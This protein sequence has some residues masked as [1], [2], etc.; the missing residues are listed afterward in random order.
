VKPPIDPALA[1]RIELATPF[2][3]Q[4][5]PAPPVQE[6]WF[7]RVLDAI[8]AF[9]TRMFAHAH[10]GHG[11]AALALTVLAA[12]LALCVWAAVR[13]GITRRRRAPGPDA[14]T[15]ALAR[16]DA[17]LA[18]AAFEAADRG[19]MTTAV[20]LLLRAAVTLLDV[21]GAIDD[22]ASATIGQLR[23]EV[24]R[25]GDVVAAAFDEIASAYVAG[26][27]AERPVERRAWNGARSA[28]ELLRSSARP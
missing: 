6:P 2:R 14:Q 28:Y 15:A 3:Y 11:A 8:Q 7:A 10:A 20:R 23:R 21:R 4:L 18:R 12:A 22:D 16:D 17:R 26:V 19:E 24:R 5:S 25:L 27:Y 13:L 1:A 9:L